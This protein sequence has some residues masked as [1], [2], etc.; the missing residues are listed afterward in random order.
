MKRTIPPDLYN[1]VLAL[2]TD[3][4]QPRVGASNH[5]DEPKASDAMTRLRA[6]FTERE[7][8]GVADPFLTE[9]LADFT[10]DK[11]EAIRLYQLSL[12]QCLAFPGEGTVSKRIGLTRALIQTGRMSDASTH[13]ET[14]RREAFAERDAAALRELDD[15]DT[16][17]G[18]LK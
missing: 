11:V 7:R 17:C 16:I 2:T 3:I 8:S 14:A 10:D 18:A 15:L 4:A 6:L 13:I 1:E 12:Q 9:T 5:V